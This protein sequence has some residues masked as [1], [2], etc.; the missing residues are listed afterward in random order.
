MEYGLE[1]KIE[2]IALSKCDCLSEDEIKKKKALLKKHTK[3]EI[4]A[5][6]AAAG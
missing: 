3:Q 4:Y 5:I 6:S 1:D 2:V